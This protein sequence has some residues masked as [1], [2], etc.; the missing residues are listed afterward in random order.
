MRSELETVAEQQLEKERRL[1]ADMAQQRQQLELELR[2]L[3]DE[4]EV[5][6]AQR[7]AAIDQVCGTLLR[8]RRLPRA[9]AAAQNTHGA[10]PPLGERRPCRPPP[11]QPRRVGHM[12]TRNTP[13]PASGAVRSHLVTRG[14]AVVPTA[15]ARAAVCCRAEIA[16]GEEDARGAARA[17]AARDGAG[18][19]AAADAGRAR[20]H[21]RAHARGVARDDGGRLVAQVQRGGQGVRRRP[22]PAAR[23]LRP[24]RRAHAVPTPCPPC[25]AA[26]CAPL[27]CPTAAAC[28]PAHARSYE[29]ML[30]QQRA[31]MEKENS[32]AL[33]SERDRRV[34]HLQSV[35]VRRIGQMGLSRCLATWVE[36]CYEAV[37]RKNLLR[38]AGARLTK[39]KLVASFKHWY[40]D[41][42]HTERLQRARAKQ[43]Q[44][45]E[46][47]KAPSPPRA[48]ARCPPLR[49]FSRA[50][51]DRLRPHVR[52]VSVATP[53]ARAPQPI[54]LP[55]TAIRCH[56]LPPRCSRVL[57]TPVPSPTHAH[58]REAPR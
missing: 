3:E 4:Q 17:D 33:E 45:N 27:R 5:T 43:K 10:P 34:Q 53:L 58:R 32:S 24:P 25:R 52:V 1:A 41:W 40:F 12:C 26:R 11:P 14:V 57:L 35:A 30:E 44:F 6:A 54:P 39:P 19:P 42:E 48:R 9:R 50:Q 16:A 23:E 37:R 49:H 51:G 56:P 22:P 2:K 8:R 36:M 13:R 21:A 31:E 38:G 47:G 7:Q 28:G 15:R 20:P 18:G 55:S 46:Q 29:R